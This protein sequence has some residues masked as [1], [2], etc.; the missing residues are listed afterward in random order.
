M[1]RLPEGAVSLTS[2][3]S[4]VDGSEAPVLNAN[5]KLLRAFAPKNCNGSVYTTDCVGEPKY[6]VRTYAYDPKNP[7]VYYVSP[8]VPESGTYKVMAT[9]NSDPAVI[10]ETTWNDEL[11]L[12]LKYIPVLVEYMLYRAYS[13]ETESVTSVALSR[14]HLANFYNALGV[15]YKQET[16]MHSG[17]YLGQRGSGDPNAGSR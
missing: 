8:A 14:T 16:R 2:I 1:Q 3:D 15:N 13:K 9:V 11:D 5:L 6:R 4:N 12:P 10:D 17:Y 7:G